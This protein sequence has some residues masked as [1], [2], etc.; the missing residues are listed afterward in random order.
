M[1]LDFGVSAFPYERGLLMCISERGRFDHSLGEVG[2]F[3][4]LLSGIVAVRPL[5]TWS[6]V[7]KH[8]RCQ[9]E[10]VKL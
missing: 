3:T 1:P 8:M 4:G 7:M 5:V 9:Q 10:S 6:I 2:E